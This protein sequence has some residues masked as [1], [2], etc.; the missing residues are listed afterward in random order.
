MTERLALQT[1]RLILRPFT[2]EDAHRVRLLAGDKDIASTTLNIPHPYEEGLAEEWISTHQER[3]EKGE[4]V[5]FAIVLQKTGELIGAIGLEI[6]PQHQRAEMGYWIGKPYW[7]NGYCTE[8]AKAVLRYGFDSLKLVRIQATH[9][10]RNPASGRVMQ[11]LG[12][13]REGSLRKHVKK[14]GQYEDLE[15]YSILDDDKLA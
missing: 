5:I 8:A 4:S 9:L 11:K 6:N 7:N 1:K 13:M 14:W 15:I 2:L 12:M 3:F 10:K